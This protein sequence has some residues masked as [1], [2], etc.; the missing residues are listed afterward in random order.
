[1]SQEKRQVPDLE[2]FF[3]WPSDEPHLIGARCKGWGEY[4]FPKFVSMH[5]PECDLREVEE[6][7][8]GRKGKLWSYTVAYY[9]TERFLI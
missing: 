4:F 6:V 9:N 8:L 2:G 3:T 1:M 5:N 7:L